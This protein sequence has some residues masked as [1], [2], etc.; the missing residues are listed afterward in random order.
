VWEDAYGRITNPEQLREDL[1]LLIEQKRTAV[2]GN[3]DREAAAW[4]SK[5]ADLER[6]RSGYLDLAA[7]GVMTREEL[8]AKLAA[9]EEARE[10]ARRELASLQ[11]QQRSLAQLEHDKEALLTHYEAITPAALRDLEPEERGRFYKLLR[12]RVTARPEGGL[13]VS[14]GEGV[15]ELESTW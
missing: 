5:L 11:E 12:L 4:L 7:D 15:C 13:E 6:K 10:T 9:V 8:G 3:P 1:E 2:R 14:Y